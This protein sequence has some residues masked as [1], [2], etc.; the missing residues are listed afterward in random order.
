MLRIHVISMR[1]SVAFHDYIV[2]PLPALTG[3]TLDEIVPQFGT[4]PLH[5]TGI[6]ASKCPETE[7]IP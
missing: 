3:G 2:L 1:A 5:L 7:P 6:F 4:P